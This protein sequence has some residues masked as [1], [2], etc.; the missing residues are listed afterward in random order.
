[1]WYY[2]FQP[3]IALLYTIFVLL[4]LV[5]KRLGGPQKLSE[6]EYLVNALELLKD[7][8]LDK[9]DHT[10]KECAL[11][12]SQASHLN[13]PLVSTLKEAL[14]Q[15]DALPASEPALPARILAHLYYDRERLL[16][17]RWLPRAIMGVFL[18][19]GAVLTLLS[20]ATVVAV[21]HPDVD[22]TM[23]DVGTTFE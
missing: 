6:E 7:A 12:L 4:F 14:R 1:T 9:T 17:V 8:V 10:R 3:T 15:I 13:S 18:V 20:F 16:M 21:V 2:F 5:F 19:H 23:E 22:F 11:L